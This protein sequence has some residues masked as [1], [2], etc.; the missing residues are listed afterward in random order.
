MFK[1]SRNK[2]SVPDLF[3]VCMQIERGH[4]ARNHTNKSIFSLLTVLCPEV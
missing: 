2:I 1:Y 3:N 4:T